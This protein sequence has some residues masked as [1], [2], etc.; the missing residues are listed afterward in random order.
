MEQR[1][2]VGFA[3]A[4]A[5]TFQV[6][7]FVLFQFPGLGGAQEDELVVAH[8]AAFQQRIFLFAEAFKGKHHLVAVIT[9]R[10]KLLYYGAVIVI[11][12]CQEDRSAQCHYQRHP[13]EK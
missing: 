3:H 10:H 6:G 1:L 11:T 13:A 9:F 4:V 2:H 7:L 8:V 12:A 5:H